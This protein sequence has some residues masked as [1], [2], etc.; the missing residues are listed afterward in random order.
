RQGL[1][2]GHA[3]RV[4]VPLR[5]PG[6]PRRRRLGGPQDGAGARLPRPGHGLLGLAMT[7]APTP[8]RLAARTAALEA[9]LAGAASAERVEVTDARPLSGGAIQENWLLDLQIRGGPHA[10]PLEA[11]LRTDAPSAVAVSRSRAEEF[12]LLAVARAAGVTAP[13][14][15]W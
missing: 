12:A 4:D 13:E 15:L 6:A 8:S 1:L 9:F 7:A 5:P 10:G 2:Q 3:A 11:V 14:P